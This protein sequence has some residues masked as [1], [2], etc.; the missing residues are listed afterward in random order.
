MGQK[1]KKHRYT[2]PTT[3]EIGEFKKLLGPLASEYTESQIV[4]LYTEMYQMANLL[5][6]IY[7]ERLK[8]KNSR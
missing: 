2:R 1:K 6:D 7:E 3:D 8:K 4:Q 5:L